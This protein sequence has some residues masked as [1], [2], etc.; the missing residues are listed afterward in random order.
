MAHV[1]DVGHIDLV[2]GKFSGRHGS[3]SPQECKSFY[4]NFPQPVSPAGT[5]RS[6][7]KSP[8]EEN[9]TNEHRTRARQDERWLHSLSR[10][11]PRQAR[12][13]AAHEPAIVGALSR[14]D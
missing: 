1:F 7:R 3:S 5:V 14:T 12:L 13:S 2:T 8:A 6:M 4:G 11:R 9:F 10:S